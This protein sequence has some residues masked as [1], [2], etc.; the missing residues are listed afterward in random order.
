MNPQIYTKQ[1]VNDI[2]RGQQDETLAKYLDK[3]VIGDIFMIHVLDKTLTYE[4]DQILIVTPDDVASLG[5]EKGSDY[6]TL[7]TCT[8]YGVNSHRLLVR[9]HRIETAEESAA[10][11]VVANAIQIEPV[12]VAPI[13]ALPILLILLMCLVLKPKR[14]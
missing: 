13:I 1:I 2:V 11:H 5:I 4:V 14:R 10:V 8:P 6:C 12:V 9:G 3:L 7:I